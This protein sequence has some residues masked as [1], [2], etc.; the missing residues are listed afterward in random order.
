MFESLNCI[1]YAFI[2]GGRLK[3]KEENECQ[4]QNLHLLL[5]PISLKQNKC[6]VSI[7]IYMFSKLFLDFFKSY[8]NYHIHTSFRYRLLQYPLKK[9]RM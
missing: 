8:K 5:L 2:T 7:F 6:S 3:T 4:D 9:G 1:A